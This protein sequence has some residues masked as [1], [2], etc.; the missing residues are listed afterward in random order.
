LHDKTLTKHVNSIEIII[1]F[2]NSKDI[3]YSYVGCF[4]G[5]PGGDP[6]LLN[7][8][9]TLKMCGD[10]C[11]FHGADYMF[12]MPDSYYYR[13]K[14]SAYIS[15]DSLK[16]ILQLRCQCKNN[17]SINVIQRNQSECD[18]KCSGDSINECGSSS[19][20]TL[21]LLVDVRNSNFFC[22]KLIKYLNKNK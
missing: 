22:D 11:G 5:Y 16:D 18:M 13:F 8:Y 19:K 9:M 2:C 17:T 4:T 10:F 3:N 14:L 20:N 12:V 21:Y 1:K 6:T 15:Y 7:P